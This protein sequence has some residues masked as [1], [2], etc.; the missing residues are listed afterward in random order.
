MTERERAEQVRRAAAGDLDALQRLFVHYHGTL[1]RVVAAAIDPTLRRYVEPDDVLQQT[2]VAAFQNVAGR[3]FD[4]PGHLYKW[5][6]RIALN[7]LKD[8]QRA[9]R[10]QK[11]DVAREVPDRPAPSASYPD[12][13]QRLTA[14]DSTPSRQIARDEAIAA[15][16]TSLARLGDEQRAVVRL[17]ILEDVPVAEI[18]R[19][20]GKSDVAIY[21]LCRRGL[22][23]LKELL[24]SITRY[25]TRL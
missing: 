10:R 24:G 13:I 2:Y 8:A 5:L 17:R 3:H 4:G 25:L 18:A 12:L 7:Q 19:R 16:M 21:A 6:E 15:V 20:L 9:L 1:R 22:Q 23:S 11:R 14:G